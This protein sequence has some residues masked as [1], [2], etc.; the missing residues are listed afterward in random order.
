MLK[1]HNLTVLALNI[2][3]NELIVPADDDQAPANIG[4]GINIQNL[5]D[6][7]YRRDTLLQKVLKALREGRTKSKL[8]ALRDCEN[9][10]GYL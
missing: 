6:E 5:I 4:N 3:N 8:L 9:W 2:N 7:G 10:G 1:S